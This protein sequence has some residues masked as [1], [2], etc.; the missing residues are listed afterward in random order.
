M[1]WP[2]FLPTN[3]SLNVTFV[4]WSPAPSQ[5]AGAGIRQTCRAQ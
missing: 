4:T 5:L 3:P 2:Q 1:D